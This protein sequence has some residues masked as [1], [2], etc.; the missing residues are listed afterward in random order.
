[1]G[2]ARVAPA[3]ALAA[4]AALAAGTARG[5]TAIVGPAGAPADLAPLVV[6]ADRDD[7]DAD[8]RP[9]AEQDL[10]PP[11]ARADVIPLDPRLT[12]AK[13]VAA[14]GGDRAR[15]VVGDRPFAWGR[16]LPPRAAV[17]GIAP[18][19]VRLLV[20]RG[21]RDEELLVDV[22]GLGVRDGTLKEVDAAREHVSLER[23][24]PERV[25]G[26]V[27][28]RY[29]DA[30]AVRLV[31]RLPRSQPTPP[32]VSIESVTAA[33]VHLDEIA[34]PGL[35]SLPC[36]TGGVQ[37]FAS[38]PLRL[39]VDEV[40]RI[41]PAVQSRSLRAE[42]GGALVI[43][44]AGKKAQMIR[45]AGPRRSPIGPIGR[46]RTSIHPIVVRV[47]PG[48]APAIG[49]SDAGA[50]A[51]IRTELALAGAVW[52]QC[53]IS[54]GPVQA[55]EVKVVDPPPPHLIAF[56]DD[57]GLPASGGDLRV[58]ADGHLL[59][60]HI[61]PRTVPDAA[62]R[63]FARVA[64][65]A[66][67]VAVVS[68]NARIA[69]GATGSVDVSLRRADGSLVAIEPAVP[70]EPIATD[71][72]LIVRIGTVDFAD[73]LHHF[74]DMDS[75]AGTLEE[76]TLIKAYDDGDPRTIEVVVIPHFSGGGRIGESFIQS[77]YSSVRNVVLLDRA[78]I[79]ARRSS[80]TLAHELGH[81]FMNVPGHPDDFGLD[82]PTLLMDSDASDASPFGPRRIT[83]EECARV[84]RESG[85]AAR[86]PLL[87][88]WPLAPL[89]VH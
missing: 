26:G 56:G 57:L 83:A 37:C 51:A 43:R 52:G 29:D 75:M 72:T 8:G 60:M 42:V 50:V 67:L 61:A 47:A 63:E 1:M 70:A 33:G 44:W 85:P 62:A 27:T 19:A 23:T 16:P 10:L 32:P 76:R 79:R 9:D 36:T 69:P 31:V 24:P 89:V 40:D 39:V 88:D 14:A 35:E 6:F 54:F 48:G 55:L 11:A 73:G 80:L 65:K 15:L 34:H 2:L 74:G 5:G 59:V 7:D 30:D 77:D 53:G 49:G 41:H 17:Q 46:L 64:A 12:G 84:V 82:T 58:R 81:V 87:T 3:A 18:G 86:V 45:V 71:P 21:G 38:T 22:V 13:L 68:P 25:E 4:I 20:S 78:G 28:A 66:H